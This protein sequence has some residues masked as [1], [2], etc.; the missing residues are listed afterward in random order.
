MTIRVAIIVCTFNRCQSLSD[1]LVSISRLVMPEGVLCELIVVDNNSSDR[2]AEIVH[3]HKS[4]YPFPLRYAF[5]PQQG[6]SFARNRGVSE[7]DAEYIVFTDDDILV[8]R[9]WLQELLEGFASHNADCVGGKVLPRWLAA[10]PVWLDESLLNVLAMLDYGDHEMRIDLRTSPR[11]LY[12]AN[13]AF[14]RS[15]LLKAGPFD[16]TL[17]RRGKF[18]AGEDKDILEKLSKAGAC[19]MYWPKAV[20]LHKVEPERMTKSYFRLW[21]SNVGRDRARRPRTT[22]R[23]FGVERHLWLELLRAAPRVPYW[24]ARGRADRAFA[25]ELRCILYW[26]VISHELRAP[27][28]PA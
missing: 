4:A 3:E 21:H 26:S 1:T 20:V 25:Y 6:L 18:G 9:F 12:G 19:I 11:M 10:R 16:V 15:A 17:G 28:A 8:D 7:T 24:L 27:S 13:F 2:T 22:K 23:L 5:E 14:R